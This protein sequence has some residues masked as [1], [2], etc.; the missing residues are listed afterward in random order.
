MLDEKKKRFYSRM[1]SV[2]NLLMG[3]CTKTTTENFSNLKMETDIQIQE[4]QTVQNKTSPKR[5]TSRYI[6]M[7]MSKVKN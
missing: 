1:Y 5:S 4:T 2:I 6:I 7:K 3:N